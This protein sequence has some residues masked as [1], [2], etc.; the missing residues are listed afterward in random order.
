MR[1]V[2]RVLAALATSPRSQ[3][4]WLVGEPCFAPPA[5][6]ADAFAAAAASTSFGYPPHAGL[7]TLREVLAA[8][9]REGGRPAT[10]DQVVVT[11]GAKGGLLALFAALLEPGD[12][13]IHPRPC[14]PAYPTMAIRLGARPVAVAEGDG[15]F[16][17]W[18]GAVAKCIGPRTRAVVL[19]SPSNPTG[20][21]LNQNQIHALVELC[22]D[23]GLRLVCD[24]AYVDFRFASGPDLVPADLDPDRSTV[25]QVRSASKSWAVCG[26][27]V[28]WVV[29]DPDL[30]DKVARTH[31]ALLNPASGPA[32]EALTAVAGVSADHIVRARAVVGERLDQLVT[33][34][35]D[36]G[37]AARRPEGG[38]YLWLD[39]A[40]RIRHD[41]AE[42]AAAWCVDLAH[43]F[44]IGLWPG[45]DFGGT[46]HIRLAVTAPPPESWAAA[47]AD[48]VRVFR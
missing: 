38:F 1:A 21:T 16:A 28:G 14:Y 17:G 27:R 25:V 6:L 34:L 37:L 8:R 13:I 7:A 10:H 33:A 11:N 19:A 30:T 22:R 26:W 35:N 5:A 15:S 4:S 39:V 3:Q 42:T 32:Q 41:R 18:P 29:A 36:T 2:D 31:A 43:Q 20:A 40:E 47:V 24:E 44:G 48:L 46:D 45:E 12:E 23:R 9:H